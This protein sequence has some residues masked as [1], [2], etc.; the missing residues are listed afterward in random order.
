MLNIDLEPYRSIMSKPPTVFLREA[1]GLV[2]NVSLIDAIS[3]NAAWMGL[4]ANISLLTLYTVYF[5]TMSG[6]NLVYG[7]V[8][9]FLLVLP[10]MYIY[11]II[12][13]RMPRTGGDY[14]WMSRQVGGLLGSALG[15]TGA[16]LN[17]IAFVAIIILSAV[18]SIGS[19][20]LALGNQ[21]YLGLALPGNVSGSNPM[22]QLI[23]GSIIFTV[24]VLINIVSP[25]LAIKLLTVFVI[26]GAAGIIVAIA[27][28]L[29]GGRAGVVNYVN[30]LGIQNVTYDSVASSYTGPTF[31]L[32]NTMILMPFFFTFLFPWFN[33]STIAGSELRGKNTL[34]WSVP[35]SG[36]S[37]FIIWTAVFA[38]LYSVAGFQFINA[39]FANSTLVFD[40]G[41]NFWT[42][43]MGVANNFAL[44]LALGIAWIVWNIIFLM[45][46]IMAVAR[47]ILAL[48]FDRFLP[49]KF[50]YVSPRFN[51]PVIAHLLDLVLAI[52]LVA[53]TAFFYGPLS[54]LS[55]TAIGP[56]VFFMFVGIASV[57]YGIRRKSEKNSVRYPLI[58]A[59]I[60]SA[61]IFAFVSYQFVTL[62]SI[63][64]GNLLSYAFLLGS[65]V[66]GLLIYMAS[67]RYLKKQGL[68]LSLI[69][70]EIPPE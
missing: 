60:L 21:S 8:I 40:Y 9:G 35:I 49:S 17:F 37:V 15:L 20:G 18:F 42:L 68:D 55:T 36:F 39:A 25:K 4:G 53:A 45:V 27:V 56:M 30:S 23:L 48:S 34:K 50:A 6:V 2:K 14:V 66:G 1:T 69:F 31:D 11:T 58:I 62:P 29:T 52:I 54:A 19:V 12:Q 67:K 59:G 64:G 16:C 43:A 33:M 61:I 57:L 70:K 5:P 10:Q 63:Y 51:S 44:S 38:T 32:G 3:M 22:E 26:I 46:T 65:F 7:S 47:Y 28:L 41:F 13:R 24:L